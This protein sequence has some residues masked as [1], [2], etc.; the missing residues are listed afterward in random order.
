MK[1]I[2]KYND[3]LL[4][5]SNENLTFT[6]TIDTFLNQFNDN[7]IK[8]KL[9]SLIMKYILN[10]IYTEFKNDISI[11]DR[12][13]YQNLN[14][15][16]K[17][18][19]L[20]KNYQS[21]VNNIS[22]KLASINDFLGDNN[23]DINIVKSLKTFDSLYD[24]SV[25]Y[26]DNL[27]VVYK[28]DRTDE[29]ANTDKF[30]EYPNGWYWINLN[31]DYSEDEETNMGH[32]GRDAGKILFSLRDD[33]KQSHIT[34][35]YSVSEKAMYQCKGRK[36]RKPKDIYHEMIIDMILND[37]YPVNMMKIGS[38]KPENDFNLLDLTETKREEIFNNKPSLKLTDKMFESYFKN[39][40]YKGILSMVNNG[41][42]FYTGDNIRLY[43]TDEELIEFK[44][45]CSKLKID[46][47]LLIKYCFSI[48]FASRNGHIEVV[49]L[50]IG[51]GADVTADDNEAIRFA[52]ENGHIEVVKLLIGA[53]ADVTADDNEAIRFA[54]E[55]GHI[56]VVKLLI[57]NGADV[58]ADD[59]YA[60]RY[61]SRN[62]HIEIVKLLIG[63]G[64]DV[65]TR[66]N[67]AIRFASSN[68]HIEVVKLLID[69]GADVTAENNYAIRWASDDGH[70]EIVKLLIDNG[71]DVT[72]DGNQAIRW[73]SRYGHIEVVKLLKKHGATL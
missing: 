60:I 2:L 48:I 55:N 29:T 51:A 50:L 27:S 17:V 5:E 4:K 14:S 49:K 7:R 64:A 58:T 26:H 62:G 54:S 47:T 44:V 30:I 68:G 42:T 21:I 65:T 15:F 19:F 69:A 53:G 24:L 67:H 11:E 23:T 70:L 57:D 20:C 35:S 61:A 36:N 59:N 3:F 45:D 9:S 32:C 73:A 33:N 25:Q 18:N 41:Y 22:N 1:Y 31:V 63:A 37:K 72:A 52:S 40:D 46:Y 12:K 56:E 34:A 39:K 10:N 38:Y 28:K 43:Y 8:D 66:G 71:A 6:R 16:D 13:T